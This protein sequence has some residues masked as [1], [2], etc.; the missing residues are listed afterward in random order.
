MAH[1]ILMP[2]P[3]QMTE[4]CT[5]VA[6]HKN[7]GDAVKKGDVLFEIET[8]KSNMD[9]EAFDDG[10]LLKIIAAEGQT[11]PV[12][13]VCA[14]VGQP[15]EAIPEM[16]PPP[17]AAV[18]RLRGCRGRGRARKSRRP[19]P[20][21]APVLGR[22][23]PPSTF[24]HSPTAGH[25]RISPRQPAC[26]RLGRRSPNHHRHG[27][28]GPDHRARRQGGRS[29]QPRLPRPQLRRRRSPGR[30]RPAR[31]GRPSRVVPTSSDPEDESPA[32]DEPDAPRH[33]RAADPE[34]DHRSAIH[35]DGRRRHDAPAGPA[36]R[37]ERP[38]AALTVTDFHR[39]GRGPDAREFPDVNS[40]TDGTSVWPPPPRPHRDGRLRC[41]TVWSCRSSAT[42]I[43]SRSRAPRPGRGAG[44]ERRE[45][46]HSPAD[47]MTGSTFT[48][49]NLGMFG[50]DEFSAII[51][52]GEAGH[53]G[54]SSAPHA[55]RGRGRDRHAADHEADSFGR[56]PSRRRRAWRHV[57]E[58][59]P[60]PAPG[61]R[62]IPRRRAQRL[63]TPQIGGNMNRTAQLGRSG[64]ASGSTTSPATCSTAARSSATSTSCRSRA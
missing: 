7:E 52:P 18:A 17:V 48:V 34:L 5:L 19:A 44:R 36:D 43:A 9:V 37:S 59:A 55:D 45:T 15:G 50:V 53:P 26:R 3:G 21:A 62:R 56:P 14:Y 54:R 1:P 60:A 30:G 13:T 58:R 38:P 33:R 22:R 46:A 49:S 64:R 16:S 40:R 4:E 28:G 23:R 47:D 32:A 61:C 12:N 57:P 2:K 35:G 6:W 29:T 31:T 51:N 20:P 42:P 8:D 25:L 27:A 63:R 11:V 41:R 24:R 10:V 39:L